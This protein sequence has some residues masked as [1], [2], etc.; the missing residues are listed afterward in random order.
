MRT[1]NA[2]QVVVVAAGLMAGCQTAE[3]RGAT[4]SART[5]NGDP[6]STHG[7]Y[8][9]FN[10][11]WSVDRAEGYHRTAMPPLA[12]A[13]GTAGDTAAASAGQ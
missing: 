4:P 5:L 10:L 7:L 12:S 3:Y 1:G 11:N 6:Q 2:W 9:G 13:S 8:V